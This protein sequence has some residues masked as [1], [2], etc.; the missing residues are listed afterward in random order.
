MVLQSGKNTVVLDIDEKFV[1]G[2]DE[3]EYD[4]ILNPNNIQ[5]NEPHDAFTITARTDK[6]LKIAIIIKHNK[7]AV[8]SGL[9]HEDELYATIDND[10][11][12]I[13]IATGEL[14]SYEKDT[15]PEEYDFSELDELKELL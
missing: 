10:A 15:V 12:I 9:L 6:I 5:R 14:K 11:I 3:E 4:I 7:D 1:I 13:N 2:C 8:Y